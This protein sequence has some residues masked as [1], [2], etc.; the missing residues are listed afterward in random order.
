VDTPL[1]TPAAK[2]AAGAASGAVAADME[3][4]AI[5][6]AAAGAGVPFAAVRVIVDTLGDSLPP[7]AERWVDARGERRLAPVVGAAFRPLEWPS[8]W[9]LAS[10]YRTARRSLERLAEHLL[11]QRFAAPANAGTRRTG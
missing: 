10:R 6:A 8:L 3:S 2:A 9:L 7:G 4:A 5:A 1:E 11:P